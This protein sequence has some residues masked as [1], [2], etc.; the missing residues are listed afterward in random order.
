LDHQQSVDGREFNRM[1][2]KKWEEK[3]T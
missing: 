3:W 1:Q 2:N